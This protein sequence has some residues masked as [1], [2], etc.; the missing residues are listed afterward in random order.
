MWAEF[1]TLVLDNKHTEELDPEE[2]RNWFRIRGA[3]MD[4]VEKVLD[5]AWNFQ[6]AEVIVDNYREPKVVRL[7]HSPNI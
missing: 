6:R 4:K 7:A 1:F 5:Q 3:N 2:I